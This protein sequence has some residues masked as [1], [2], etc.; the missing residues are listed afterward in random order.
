MRRVVN[1]GTLGEI[2]GKQAKPLEIISIILGIIAL[3]ILVMLYKNKKSR[4][5]I[6]SL[7]NDFERMSYYTYISKDKIKNIKSESIK[8][9]YPFGWEETYRD[10]HAD[11]E[12]LAEG[13][14]GE[15]FHKLEPFLLKQGIQITQMNEDINELG[16][17]IEING[18][19]YTIYTSEE[20]ENEDFWALASNRAFGIINH[21]LTQAHT[22][23][24]IYT[25]YGGNDQRAIFLTPKMF[26]LI[27]KTNLIENR[28]KPAKL[29]YWFKED[30]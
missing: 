8:A 4:T 16:Y 19:S 21:L 10:F 18:A 27:Q 15:F 28:E 3:L 25:L 24:R 22:E 2:S 7:I 14:I 29:D 13:G 17:R 1:T 12:D 26:E 20:L 5:D 6:T 9:G 11:A 30:A 23:E